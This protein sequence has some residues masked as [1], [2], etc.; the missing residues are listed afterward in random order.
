VQIQV[1]ARSKAWVYGRSL[2]G[3]VCSNLVGNNFISY[4]C[5]E[6]SVRGVCDE[7]I[8]RPEEFHRMWSIW[9]WSRNFVEEA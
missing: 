2:A 7:P 9:V 8:T 1:L 5:C 3:I 4:D 6:L